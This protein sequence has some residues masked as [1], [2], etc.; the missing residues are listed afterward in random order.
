LLH[1][2]RINKGVTMLAQ[3]RARGW[4][5]P[6][7]GGHLYVSCDPALTWVAGDHDAWQG[8]AMTA[9]QGFHWIVLNTPPG[10]RYKF[11]DQTNLVADPWSRA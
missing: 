7:A 9:D 3:S 6:V 4:P 11:S 1:K 5:A 2:L 8:T 10:A